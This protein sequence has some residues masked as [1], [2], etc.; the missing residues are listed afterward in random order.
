M[1]RADDARTAIDG[2]GVGVLPLWGLTIGALAP[3]CAGSA[4]CRRRRRQP[5]SAR[6]TSARARA[7]PPLGCACAPGAPATRARST[8]RSRGG[9]CRAGRT[10]TATRRGCA[11]CSSR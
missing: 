3:P 8:R 1:W 5:R 11:P 7:T 2:A 10:P 9:R 6:R 4:S